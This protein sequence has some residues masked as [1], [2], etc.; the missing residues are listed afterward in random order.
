MGIDQV[1]EIPPMLDASDPL[2]G[3]DVCGNGGNGR[4]Q[5]S[6]CVKATLAVAAMR[7]PR[8]TDWCSQPPALSWNCCHFT[9]SGKLL[10][11]MCGLFPSMLVA[12][13]LAC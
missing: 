7:Q 10:G 11:F 2:Q 5:G 13:L 4:T 12:D 6:A 3:F 8:A 9:S 1:L